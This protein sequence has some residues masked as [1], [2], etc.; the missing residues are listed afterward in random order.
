[1]RNNFKFLL[2]M[3]V[4]CVFPVSGTI[5]VPN[6]DGLYF[7]YQR[8]IYLENLCQPAAWWA[9]PSLL[10]PIDRIT[11]FTSNTGLIGQRYTISSARV[12]LPIQSKLNIGF[13]VT[14]TGTTE[15][16]S[17]SAGN[18]GAQ[19]SSSFSFNLP[20]LEAGVSYIPPVVGSIGA[21]M[22]TGTES[23]PDPSNSGLNTLYFFWGIGAGWLSPSIMNTVKFSVSTLS[24]YH[25][26]FITWWDNGAKAG[27]Q[28]NVNDGK[29]TGS[30][31][32]GFALFNG[33]VSFFQNQSN[34]HGY[35]IFKGSVSL[36]M[37]DIAG[38]L[39]G[40]SKDTPPA[41]AID[42][43]GST[44]HAGVELRR[45]DVYPYYGGYEMGI[46]GA[47]GISIIHRIWVGY[48]FKKKN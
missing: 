27:L 22:I 41:N 30:F 9:N 48:G 31:E 11:V 23:I 39:L 35:E 32:Y 17:L 25:S 46:S 26:Q 42:N 14:G 4:F 33:P 8:S 5:N 15:G 2:A 12:V 7:F 16:R 28:I 47:H 13:G 36:K 29:V 38:V 44:F 40:Y 21:L 34:F 19:Y 10:S 3:A 6:I 18:G 1:M 37:M 45:S 24:V 43:N 20:S